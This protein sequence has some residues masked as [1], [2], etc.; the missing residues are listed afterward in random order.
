MNN[1]KNLILK[2]KYY[3]IIFILVIILI[4]T[5][6]FSKKNNVIA[7]EKTG[8]DEVKN[9]I[10][11][12]EIQE[13]LKIDIKGE[14][15]N[16]GVYEL[17]IN[18]RVIDA[19]NLAGGLKENSDTSYINLSKKLIDEMVI[20]VYSKEEIEK[21]KNNEPVIVYVEKECICPSI[22]NDACIVENKQNNEQ[23]TES[24]ININTANLEELQL[25]DGIGE[26][27]A[28]TIIEYREEHGDF[29]NIEEIM[30]VSGIGE[31][32]Y[33]KIKDSITI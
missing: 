26:G 17:N 6:I 27:K 1:I 24:K 14:V 20:I 31:A 30:N 12:E 18:D 28:K 10:I 8:I 3:I 25:L 19:I 33:S 29:K 9:E 23:N 11:V 22:E 15:V 13:K 7:E 16:P 4:M 5:G 21:M 2:Y 32:A